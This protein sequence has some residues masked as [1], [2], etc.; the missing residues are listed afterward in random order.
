MQAS[1]DTGAQL[2]WGNY[3]IRRSGQ[4][5]AAVTGGFEA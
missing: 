4:H 5:V 1:D 2:S 3:L